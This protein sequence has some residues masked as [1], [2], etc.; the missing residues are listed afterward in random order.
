MS[1]LHW[2]ATPWPYLYVGLP[3]V[4][5]SA[6]GLIDRARDA[7]RDRHPSTGTRA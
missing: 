2:L 6:L 5:W 7:A 4:G 1:T 3:A